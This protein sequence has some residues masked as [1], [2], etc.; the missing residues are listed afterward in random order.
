M[1]PF[2]DKKTLQH[3]QEVRRILKSTNG[4]LVQSRISPS[5]YFI[6]LSYQVPELEYP[7]VGISKSVVS[8]C[9]FVSTLLLDDTDES[10]SISR[11]IVMIFEY[12]FLVGPI[13]FK[14]Q[15]ERFVNDVTFMRHFMCYIQSLCISRIHAHREIGNILVS[16]DVYN[17]VT[18][19]ESS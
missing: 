9:E 15:G 7:K 2:E 8:I 6:N 1:C 5:D 12:Y 19:N 3:I 16:L 13:I 14:S 4:K 10:K 18:N 17:P 11:I